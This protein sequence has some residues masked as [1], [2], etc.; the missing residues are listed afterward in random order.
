MSVGSVRRCEIVC[1][2]GLL[3]QKKRKMANLPRPLTSSVD[4]IFK[5]VSIDMY[6]CIHIGGGYLLV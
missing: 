5:V 1:V 6:L 3:G 4:W 2:R